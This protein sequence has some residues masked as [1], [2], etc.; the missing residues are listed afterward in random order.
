MARYYSAAR[1]ETLTLEA[2][3]AEGLTWDVFVSH[4]TKD[5]ALAEEVAMCIRSFGL[6]AWVDSDNLAAKNDGPGMASKIQGAIIRSYC[7]LAVVTNATNASWWVPFEIGIAWD[8]NKYLST[9]G[10]PR[11]PLPSFLAAWPHVK[12]REML[13]SWCE[14]M[15]SKKATYRPTFHRAY[16]EVASQQR[17][18]YASEMRGMAQ[19]FPGPR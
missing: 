4:T 14:E 6:T 3:R 5:D 17:S 13:R 10:D 12:D 9:Y 11:V 8:R 7:L 16:V 15:K 19:R 1:T 2:A 18:T